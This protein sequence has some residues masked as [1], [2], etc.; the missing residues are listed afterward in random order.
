MRAK[1]ALE[2][3]LNHKASVLDNLYNELLGPT[4]IALLAGPKHE[5]AGALNGLVGKEYLKMGSNGY[6]RAELQLH[7]CKEDL[8]RNLA[9]Q[10]NVLG[11]AH[12]DVELADMLGEEAEG[13][14]LQFL[15]VVCATNELPLR[16]SNGTEPVD[17]F[18]I[19][20][21]GF[22]DLE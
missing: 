18:F 3:A 9:L 19:P 16:Q 5:L 7:A 6:M 21:N 11:P 12:L 4:G 2:V 14:C 8:R 1:L 20:G 10:S 15:N 13:G 17:L 22:D